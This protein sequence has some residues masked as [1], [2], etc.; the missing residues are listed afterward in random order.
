MN[1]VFMRHGESAYNLLGLCNDD[2]QVPVGL[3][4]RGLR[5][6]EDAAGQLAVAAFERVFVSRLP[7]A[8]ASATI[9]NRRHRAPVTVDARLDDRRSGFEG[10]P[11]ADYLAA[12]DADP[13]NFCAPGG[14]SYVTLKAR[15]LDFLDELGQA[16]ERSVLVV[17]HHEVLQ[18]V[19]GHTLGWSDAAIRQ[20]WIEPGGSFVVAL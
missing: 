12:R 18:I 13:Q 17:S 6:V 19:R 16:H 1:V 11:V 2:P 4:E 9:V 20:W 3:S 14:E 10:R 7:R 5:Q 15:V 8:Q